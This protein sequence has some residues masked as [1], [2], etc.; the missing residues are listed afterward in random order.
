MQMSY[1][2]EQE[3]IEVFTRWWK[4]N[5]RWTLAVL[6]LGLI[7]YI[8]WTQW[9][10]YQ[11]QRAEAASVL[12]EDLLRS[13]ETQS[14][15]TLDLASRL[16]EEYVDTFYGKAALLFL[17][18]S[19]VKKND[20]T[21]A[22]VH[23]DKLIRQNTGDDLGYIAKF[24]SAKVLHALGKDDDALLRLQE[25]VPAGFKALF[26]ELRGDV[27]MAQNQHDKAR[28]AYQEAVT[29]DEKDGSGKKEILEMKLNQAGSSP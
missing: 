2:T 10:N 14:P 4:E 15:E 19:S 3:Q 13:A 26:A 20:L 1:R 18:E 16:Q 27:Y 11:H 6:V 24:R 5:G 22:E 28:A 17:A 8:G 21:G 9:Q 29:G 12:Y 23:L 25:P 7:A